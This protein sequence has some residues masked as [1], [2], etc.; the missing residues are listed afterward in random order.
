MIGPV[1]PTVKKIVSGRYLHLLLARVTGVSCLACLSAVGS[2]E[3]ID[4]FSF[5]STSV[6]KVT[7]LSWDFFFSLNY[8]VH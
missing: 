6:E 4:L 2:K 5:R 3:I 8:Q 7:I 1:Y